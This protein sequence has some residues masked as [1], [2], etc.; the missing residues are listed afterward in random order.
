MAPSA[1]QVLVTKIAQSSAI[2]H[3][4]HTIPTVTVT[5]TVGKHGPFT[6]TYPK[7]GFDPNTVKADLQQH[8]MQLAQLTT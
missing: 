7:A 5:Y 4:G 6:E 2:D 8:A 3:F 1:N